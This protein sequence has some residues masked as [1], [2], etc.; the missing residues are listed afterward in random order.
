MTKKSASNEQFAV[1]IMAGGKG[2]RMKSDM[3][4]VLHPVAGKPMLGHVLD[5]AA[6]LAPTHTVVIVG[7]GADKVREFIS[8]YSSDV[9]AAEQTQQLGTGHAVLQTEDALKGFEGHLL[10]LSGDVPLVTPDLLFTLTE[11]HLEK[12]NAVTVVTTTADDPT[13]LGRIRRKGNQFVGIV[14]H[15][16]ATDEERMIDEINTGIYA[17]AA[18][19]IYDLLRKTGNNNAQGEYY[20]TDIVTLALQDGLKVGTCKVDDGE[21][22]LG[23]NSRAQLATTEH[24]FQQRK[25]AELMADGVTFIDPATTYLSAD[26]QIGR[27]SIIGPNCRFFENVS[28][29]ERV[30]LEGSSYLRNTTV[31]DDTHIY[32]FCHLE[33]VK[34]RA[35]CSIG[36]FARLRPG[37]LLENG[38][39]VGNFVETKA[40]TIGKGSK[41]NHLSYIGDAVVGVE[42]N[43]GAGTITC[44]YDGAN[45]H[46]TVIADGAFI[47]SNTSLVAPVKIGVG[48]TVGAG[49]TIT[50]D[51]PPEALAVT[52]AEQKTRTGYKRPAKKGA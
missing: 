42:V 11:K 9:Q 49:S 25:R 37:T 50:K 29:G 52:R 6:E 43:I 41:V 38:A 40:T 32:A 31:H 21:A 20:L 13:G 27:D 30:E 34:V 5:A 4:K 36:P 23:V 33:G 26:T 46:Q 22:L 47:G 19:L 48:A 45:K 1:A 12:D 8:A 44:N 39:K 14:E 15:K 2:T 3:P 24:L 35:K 16:D 10:I 17:V 28:L 7:H 51:V 18:P